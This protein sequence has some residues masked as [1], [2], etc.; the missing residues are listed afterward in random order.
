M[1]CWDCHLLLQ[2]INKGF[3]YFFLSSFFSSV[4]AVRLVTFAFPHWW[5]T[6]LPHPKV[7]DSQWGCKRPSEAPLSSASSYLKTRWCAKHAAHSNVSVRRMKPTLTHLVKEKHAWIGQ[8][9]PQLTGISVSPTW[10]REPQF[11]VWTEPERCAYGPNIPTR[12]QDRLRSAQRCGEICAANSSVCGSTAWAPSV[13]KDA[14]THGRKD[15]GF[16]SINY[17]RPALF[18]Q[19]LE[20]FCGFCSFLKKFMLIKWPYAS[21]F[22]LLVLS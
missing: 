18:T 15:Y 4:F 12:Q 10:V 6:K 20:T 21:T 8:G 16:P 1:W 14:R 5:M 3:F 9:H 13:H 19:P 2:L 17:A 22:S 7:K 11:P